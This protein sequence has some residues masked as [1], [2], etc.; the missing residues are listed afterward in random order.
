MAYTL[1]SGRV[2]D[3]SCPFE[4]QCWADQAC[5][6]QCPD[7]GL[8]VLRRTAKLEHETGLVPHTDPEVEEM[9]EECRKSAIKG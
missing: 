5:L 2:V 8:D 7:T 9:C 6:S 1:G 3:L 4:N